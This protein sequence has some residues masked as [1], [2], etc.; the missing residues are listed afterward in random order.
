MKLKVSYEK[1]EN[2]FSQVLPVFA[3][4]CLG[5]CHSEVSPWL[6]P[7]IQCGSPALETGAVCLSVITSAGSLRDCTLQILVYIF[8]RCQLPRNAMKLQSI[9]GSPNKSP[10]ALQE[11]CNTPFPGLSTNSL[12]LALGPN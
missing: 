10:C 9:S 7:V 3:P 8:I 4:C 6:T 2:H 5:G 11:Y 12:L 1:W